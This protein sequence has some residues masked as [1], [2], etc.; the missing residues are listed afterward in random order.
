M[1]LENNDSRQKKQLEYGVHWFRRDLR[2]AGN[3]ALQWSFKKHHGKVVGLFCFDSK[4]LSRPDF[5]P[6]RFQF[7]LK[8]LGALAMRC[9]G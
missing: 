4:F 6:N 3:P 2:V 5:S 7:F 9:D 8:T 1:P